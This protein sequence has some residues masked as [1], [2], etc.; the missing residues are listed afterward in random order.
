VRFAP[1][2]KKEFMLDL[3]GGQ[4]LGCV[5][6]KLISFPVNVRNPLIHQGFH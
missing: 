6:C 5:G 1:G 2:A 4:E 3:L